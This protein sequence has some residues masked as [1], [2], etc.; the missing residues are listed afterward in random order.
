M[1]D[2]LLLL[3]VVLECVSF[4]AEAEP[5][6]FVLVFVDDVAALLIS[7]VVSLYTFLFHSHNIEEDI[8]HNKSAKGKSNPN[9]RARMEH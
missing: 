4:G 5:S 2:F 1:L 6:L 7:F 3:V 8:I 9:I